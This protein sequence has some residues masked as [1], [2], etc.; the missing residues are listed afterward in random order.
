MKTSALSLEII[1]SPDSCG[2]S[3]ISSNYPLVSPSSSSSSFTN[4][5]WSATSSAKRNQTTRLSRKIWVAYVQLLTFWIP[6]FLISKIVK[7]T[8]ILRHQAFKEKSALVIGV[9]LFYAS[10][11]FYFLASPQM[12]C[13]TVSFKDIYDYGF[14]VSWSMIS[15]NSFSCQISGKLSFFFDFPVFCNFVFGLFLMFVILLAMVSGI[16]SKVKLST[17]NQKS[18]SLFDTPLVMHIP[19]YSEN[20]ADLL[21]TINSCAESDYVDSKKLLFVVADGLITGTGNDKSTPEYLI[22]DIFKCSDQYPVPETYVSVEQGEKELNQAR[23]YCGLYNINGHTVPYVLVVK[24]GSVKERSLGLKPGNRGK[25]DSQLIIY[26]VWFFL[27]TQV[28]SSSYIWTR[29]RIRMGASS[30]GYK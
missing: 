28:F 3:D 6:K 4:S 10:I 16:N 23:V 18:P 26:K 29:A 22:Q 21:K 12:F 17:I 27:L 14:T 9:T 8:D 11:S 20:L 7:S 19:C 15:R 1:K 25:R 13:S 2:E 30:A 5:S 24:I